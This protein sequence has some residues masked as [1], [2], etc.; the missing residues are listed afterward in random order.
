MGLPWEPP[1]SLV[2]NSEVQGCAPYPHLPEACGCPPRLMQALLAHLGLGSVS[3]LTRKE[4]SL[5]RVGLGECP[6]LRQP[7]LPADYGGASAPVVARVER[8]PPI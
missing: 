6:P 7:S 4:W 8:S 2:P 3:K 5:V 1:G